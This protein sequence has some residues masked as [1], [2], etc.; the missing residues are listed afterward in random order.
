MSYQ[1]FSEIGNWLYESEICGGD[2]FDL[3]A[4]LF[5]DLDADADGKLSRQDVEKYLENHELKVSDDELDQWYSLVPQAN[6]F[7]IP[8]FKLEKEAKNRIETGSNLSLD[9]RLTRVKR[10]SRKRLTILFRIY[11]KMLHLLPKSKVD[12]IPGPEAFQKKK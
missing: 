9:T 6:I 7:K 3:A 11:H 1:T 12:G 2:Q 8:K 4:K 10:L 5:N